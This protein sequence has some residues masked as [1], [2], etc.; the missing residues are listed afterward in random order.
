MLNTMKKLTGL[1]ILTFSIFIS[2]SCG[3]FSQTP[4]I[5]NEGKDSYVGHY[6]YGHEVNTFQP[7]G[8]K[9]IF[10]VTGSRSLLE[11][12]ERKYSNLTSRPYEEVFLE[13]EGIF[14]VPASDGFAADY[15]GQ[16]HISKVISIKKRSSED[17]NVKMGKKI[18]GNNGN[19][20]FL[21]P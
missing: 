15:D 5:E 1:F 13:I 20:K 10:W 19:D 9:E 21:S 17:C 11:V 7:C 18:N 2:Y 14:L 16:V 6:T 4:L 8:K 12:M 3:A